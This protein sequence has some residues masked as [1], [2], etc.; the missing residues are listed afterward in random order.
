MRYFYGISD[1][2][3]TIDTSNASDA[4]KTNASVTQ[5]FSHLSSSVFCI[6]HILPRG[7]IAV[8]KKMI[9]GKCYKVL[10]MITLETVDDDDDDD[11]GSSFEDDDLRQVCGEAVQ[12]DQRDVTG[13]LGPR[14]SC[15]DPHHKD[16]HIHR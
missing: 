15:Q 2:S 7:Y 12:T 11:K 16:D 14:Q 13:L 8:L 9:C 4:S 1:T 3:E 6:F 5:L 10:I